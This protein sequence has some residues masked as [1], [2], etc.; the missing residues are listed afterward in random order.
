MI[1]SRWAAATA[2]MLILVPACTQEADPSVSIAESASEAAGEVADRVVEAWVDLDEGELAELLG[3][4]KARRF[5]KV[6]ERAIDDGMITALEVSRDTDGPQ[7]VL[8]NDEEITEDTVF[9]SGY[10]VEWVSDAT[11]STLELDGSFSI[12]PAEPG[13]ASVDLSPSHLW[14]GIEGARGFVVETIWPRRGRIL[15]RDGRVIAAGRG[16]DRRYPFGSAG[17]ATVGHVGALTRAEIK[18]GVVGAEGDPFGASGLE[19]AFD[20]RLAGEPGLDLVVVGSKGKVLQE[21]GGTAPVAGKDVK[22]TLDM[23][24]QVAAE[25]SFPVRVGGAV[26]MQPR[27]GDVLVVVDPSTFDPNNFAGAAGVQPFNRAL[28]GG[29]PPGSAMKVVT[30]AAALDTRTVSPST[31]VTGPKEYMGVRNFESGEFGS[32][33]FSSAVKFSVNTAFAQVAQDLGSD[34]LTRY[35]DA[36][37]FNRPLNME[38]ATRESSFPDP[39]GLGDLMW[40]SVGQAQVIA[41]PLQMASV[42]A[43]VANEGRRME[44]RIDMKAPRSGERVVKVRT[45]RSLA[46]LMQGAVEGGTGVNARIAGTTVAGKTGTAEVDVAGERRNHAWFVCFT[47]VQKA[48]LAVAVVSE[49]GGIGGQVAAPAA[50]QILQAVLPLAP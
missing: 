13:A 35:A 31:T 47:P 3:D 36:F 11:D 45:A 6:A 28:S 16:S 18:E 20:E 2:L 44:P 27:T 46:A 26:V 19:E 8:E 24:M 7:P 32:I 50:R 1:P 40:A 5:V 9:E 43:T 34:K 12:A 10:T 49:Y 39:E 21:V 23:Q 38:L 29:Y 22:V 15:D 14:P 25:R 37:G 41:T 17:G 48:R 42:A 4:V 33:P 30:A